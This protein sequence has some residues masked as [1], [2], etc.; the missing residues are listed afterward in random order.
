MSRFPHVPSL[1]SRHSAADLRPLAFR[2][3][4]GCLLAA[5]AVALAFGV[6]AP[7]G[8]DKIKVNLSAKIVFFF[9][10]ANE[11]ALKMKYST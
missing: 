4:V 7:S 11:F 5:R 2:H 10:A 3:G 9:F 1:V 6:A 8:E